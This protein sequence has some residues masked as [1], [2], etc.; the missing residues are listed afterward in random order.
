MRVLLC[1]YLITYTNPRSYTQTPNTTPQ[2]PEYGIACIDTVL[3]TVTLGQFSDDSQRTR[4]RT[5]V[6]KYLPN[7]VIL[8]RGSH[9]DETFGALRLLVRG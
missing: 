3:G 2:V 7:E 1:L 8:E 6:S 4:L 5:M 9:S